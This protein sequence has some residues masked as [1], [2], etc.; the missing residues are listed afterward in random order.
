MAWQALRKSINGFINKVNVPNI[1][2]IVVDLFGV[3]LIR[4]RGL[5]ARSLIKV[6]R[7]G[8]KAWKP[9]GLLLTHQIAFD[10]PF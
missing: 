5:F 9:V 4:G 1:Q 8:S 10:L 7:L 2:S 3:N 6:R